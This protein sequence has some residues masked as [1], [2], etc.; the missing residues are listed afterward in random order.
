[1]NTYSEKKYM[2]LKNNNFKESAQSKRIISFCVII[3]Y[4]LIFSFLWYN[5]GIERLIV[6]LI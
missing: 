3:F 1:M 6:I 4:G 2:N 5:G